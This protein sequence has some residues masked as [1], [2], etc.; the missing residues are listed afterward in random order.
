MFAVGIALGAA[1]GPAPSTSFAGAT[2]GLIQRLPA[3]IAA[4]A[5]RSHTAA[6]AQTPT[7]SEQT[8]AAEEEA[9]ASARRRR[10]QRRARKLAAASSRAEEATT[11]TAG[12]EEE[13]S[14]SSPTKKSPSA[15]SK[16]PALE[17]V[18]LV[19]LA[20]ESFSAA[21][22]APT[23]APYI[24]GT[25]VRSGALLDGWSALAGAAIAD[26]AAL[27]APVSA[28]TPPAI[29]RTPSCSLPAQKAQQAP[30]ARHPQG[31]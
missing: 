21:L 31:S 29:V 12:S 15:A 9:E 2:P 24:S 16:L 27:L 23:S 22:S 10:R 25:L 28:G 18:W 5:G 13:A 1:I 30:P 26:E 3:L 6:T 14:S 11:S 4:I 17:S 20:G 7:G 19:E 8:S